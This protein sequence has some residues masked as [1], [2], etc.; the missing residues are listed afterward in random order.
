MPGRMPTSIVLLS[1]N[2]SRL[3]APAIDSTNSIR[4][5]ELQDR[6]RAGLPAERYVA[7]AKRMRLPTP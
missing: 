2:V 7:R 4:Q 6:A 5:S 1:G 3:F